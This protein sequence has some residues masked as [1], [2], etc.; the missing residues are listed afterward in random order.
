MHLGQ[1]ALF[2]GGGLGERNSLPVEAVGPG[3]GAQAQGER[4]GGGQEGLGQNV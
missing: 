4:G 1:A 2:S 3:E